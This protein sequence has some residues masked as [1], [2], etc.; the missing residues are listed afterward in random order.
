MK[1]IGIRTC[2]ILGLL[3][4]F[5]AVAPAGQAQ[6]SPLCSTFGQCGN[7]KNLS[8]VG[9]G[10][11]KDWRNPPRYDRILPVGAN[12][13]NEYFG[14]EDTDGF[15]I[16]SGY[17][18]SVYTYFWDYGYFRYAYTVGQGYHQI[19]DGGVDGGALGVKAYHC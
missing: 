8:S 7:I 19:H 5:N 10:V 16:G 6:A 2:I 17:C 1:S 14:W 4:G 11:V 15:Y 13:S 3:I 12:W 9:I 18:A